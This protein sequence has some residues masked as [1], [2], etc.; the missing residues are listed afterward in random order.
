MYQSARYSPTTVAINDGRFGGNGD[1]WVGDGYGAGYIHRSIS[2]SDNVG[3]IKAKRGPGQTTAL[4]AFSLTVA[5]E[6]PNST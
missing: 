3:S 2:D 1:V 5:S 4:K 6:N